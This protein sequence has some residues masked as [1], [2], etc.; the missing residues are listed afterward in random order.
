MLSGKLG[1]S[2]GW[3][4]TLPVCGTTLPL[5]LQGLLRSGDSRGGKEERLDPWMFGMS[6]RSNCDPGS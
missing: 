3:H 5:S 6:G 1:V 2:E 4:K